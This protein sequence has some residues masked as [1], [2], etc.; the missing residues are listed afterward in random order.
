MN[1]HE[2][3]RRL[4]RPLDTAPPRPSKV[5]IGQVVAVG[6]RLRRRRRIA[7]ASGIVLSTAIA[8]AAVPVIFAATTPAGPV[9]APATD[10]T[11][12]P[13]ATT[14]GTVPPEPPAPPTSCVPS[15]LDP[16]VGA[17][18]EVHDSDSTGRF[19]VGVGLVDGG[20]VPLLWDNG[21][22]TVLELPVDEL[23]SSL[24]VNAQ[25]DV[26][27][28]GYVQDGSTWFP[29]PWVYRDGTYTIL[30]QLDGYSFQ[31]IADINDR[32]DI[33]GRGYQLDPSNPNARDMV[34]VVWSGSDLTP[35]VL[36]RPAPVWTTVWAIDDDGTVIGTVGTE[37][38]GPA[39][40]PD[41]VRAVVWA[42]DG[43]VRDLPAPSGYGP[44][45]VAFSVR[46]GWVLGGYEN[47]AMDWPANEEY[48][49][50]YLP[51]G[52]VEPL[53]DQ[54]RG[55]SDINRHGWYVGQ[56]EVE[57][58]RRAAVAYGGEPVL[59]PP[60]NGLRQGTATHINDDGTVIVGSLKSES[61]GEQPFLVAVRWLCS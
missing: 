30:P 25:G 3:V 17:T 41:R 58:E 4:L 48:A 44:S 18:F 35:R 59:L 28:S 37:H 51:S 33:L 52:L 32:G 60:P 13:T 57:G 7:A 23:G 2:D 6:R 12:T 46:N 19:V 54:W 40:S 29:T 27:G 61:G 45:T 10:R 42:P 34:G 39:D 55:V 21:Q 9:T 15:R 36:P 8:A 53:G 50:W 26:A 31:E 14:D 47:P 49:R 11:L 20:V 38:R 56:V 5:D 24:V 1:E 22:F 43:S 16:P